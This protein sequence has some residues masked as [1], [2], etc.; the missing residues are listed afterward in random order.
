M[1]PDVDSA[2]TVVRLREVHP[3]VVGMDLQRVNEFNLCRGADAVR[4]AGSAVPHQYGTRGASVISV[5]NAVLAV[6]GL[7]PVHHTRVRANCNG[8]RVGYPRVSHTDRAISNEGRDRGVGQNLANHVVVVVGRK[9]GVSARY[10]CDFPQQLELGGGAN[11]I[12]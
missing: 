6:P 3:S 12:R 9:D 1:Q 10:S 5:A 7:A 11:A 8:T 2:H 4:R